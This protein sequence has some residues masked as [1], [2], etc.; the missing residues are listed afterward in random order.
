LWRLRVGDWRVIFT[1]DEN[2]RL[3]DILQVSA[4]G[5]AYKP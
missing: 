5:S 1:R 4:R 3:I 2:A